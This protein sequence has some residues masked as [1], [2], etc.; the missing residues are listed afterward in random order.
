MS[1]RSHHIMNK[2]KN[3]VVRYI[4]LHPYAKIKEISLIIKI[5]E[6]TLRRW[7]NDRGR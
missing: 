2:L 4:E 6:S 1:G 7:I 3:E 5:S